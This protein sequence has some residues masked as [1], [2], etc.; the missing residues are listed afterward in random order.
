MN[1]QFHLNVDMLSFL[2]VINVTNLTDLIDLT[3]DFRENSNVKVTTDRKAS[4]PS[5]V[6]SVRK[7]VASRTKG[8]IEQLRIVSKVQDGYQL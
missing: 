3:S 4:F 2:N 8:L 6:K 7:T 1:Q 5:A